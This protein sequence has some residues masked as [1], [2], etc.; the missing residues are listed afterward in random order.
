MPSRLDQD[1]LEYH[2][3]PV[4]GKLEVTATK[5]LATQ[6]DL[7][8]AYSPG[9]AAACRAI[10]EDPA[11]ASL[12]TTRG[13][14]VAV[15]TNGTAVL[16]LGSIGPLAAKPVMEGK[17]V[18]FKKFAGIDAFDIEIN[19]Q[20]PIKL[21]D[22]VESLEPTFG[23]INLEDIKA[24]DCF[25]IEKRLRERMNI[26]V[27]H[28]DQHGTAII[29]AA[30]VVNG[31]HLVGKE[32]EEVKLV[33]SG[34]GAAALACLDLLISMGLKP[35]NLIPTDIEG[36]VYKGRTALMDPW[37]ERFAADT[38]ARTLAEAIVD[39]DVFL[40]LSAGNVLKP[41]ML[42]SMAKDP[43]VLAL[44]NPTPEIDPQLA[45][46]VREDAVIA[47]GRSDYPNQVNNVLCFP[48][49]FR[50]ALDVGATTINDEMKRACVTAIAGL[51]RM[52]TPDT[53]ASVYGIENLAFGRDYL[54]PKPFDPRLMVE[55]PAAVAQ[56]G[57]SSGVATRPIEDI[58]AYRQTLS[59]RVF[60]SGLL[61]KPL[62]ER[63]KS[64]P[65]R[66]VYADGEDVRVLRAVQVVLDERLAM[67]ILVG[68]PEVIE[69][70]IHR[71][72]LR[73]SMGRD[74]EVC[75]PDS[76][77]RYN[78]Y[79][80]YYLERME[81]R[82]ITPDAA[83]DIVRTRRTVIG[84]IM[85]SR[86]EADALITGPV[87]SFGSHLRHV[88]DVIGLTDQ[89]TEASTLHALVLDSGI[90]FIADTYVSF[91]P[92]AEEIATT[93]LKAS[94]A[95]RR[96]GLQPKVAL[97]SHSNFGNRVNPSSRKMRDALEIVRQ[98]APD[99]EVDGEM[100]ADS[101]L[102]E[103][104]RHR[105]LPS[106]SLTGRANL[107]IMP[108]LDAANIAYNLVKS[109]TGTVSIGPIL[110]GVRKPAH[111]VTSSITTRG[112]VNMSALAC[113]DAI[114]QKIEHENA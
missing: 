67:P 105:L 48:F 53:V 52:T 114:T 88:H 40:G 43:L 47:T 111:I 28:D 56:A 63:A 4:A 54:I 108:N 44:A 87:G 31:L 34:A 113:V 71:L 62:F 73:M 14:L 82:G 12:L 80:A 33:S 19:E 46:E 57:M 21:A 30:A 102:S 20:D 66:L 16:G 110:L 107:L 60:R 100:H 6:R 98:A 90:L 95:V 76:D 1:A 91:D 104:I 78:D 41:E 11:E 7:S 68:R 86:G 13:N 51:A 84:S 42:A 32:L 64:D 45:R 49:I 81:R 36:V 37:K 77:P 2:R 24:P 59:Q 94:D 65:Q 9:V 83:R 103:T 79:V 85:V 106:S 29:V 61:M 17:A 69:T 18:L 35:E 3:G 97:I 99:L 27:F 22:I 70:R 23:A 92:P 5:P 58:D 93:T 89:L 8:L 10:A 112:L 25:I 72:G 15:V 55:V 39:A 101:A 74:F 38:G 96:F 26:P 109:V 50:G 75:N